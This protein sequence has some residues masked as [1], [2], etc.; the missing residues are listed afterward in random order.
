MGNRARVELY[1]D[2]GDT[3]KNKSLFDKMYN[4]RAI[5]QKDFQDEI[6]WERLDEKRSCRIAIYRDGNILD[7]S[8]TLEEIKRWSIQNVL[9]FKKVFHAKLKKYLAEK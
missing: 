6:E 8:E 3:D 7:N 4:N 5:F 9:L 2:Q 1:I